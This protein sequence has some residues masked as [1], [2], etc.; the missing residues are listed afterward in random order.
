MDIETIEQEA[1]RRVNE[2]GGKWQPHEARRIE[3]FD[4]ICAIITEGR[5]L[6]GSQQ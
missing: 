3:N 1:L 2:H 5:A 4:L 6:K